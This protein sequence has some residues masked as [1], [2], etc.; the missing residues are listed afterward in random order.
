[1]TLS[2]RRTLSS[3]GIAA[4]TAAAAPLVSACSRASATPPDP[5]EAQQAPRGKTTIDWWYSSVAAKDGGDLAPRLI[6]AFR[7]RYPQISVNIIK[8]PASTDT[9]RSALSTQLAAGSASPDVYQGDITWAAQFGAASFALPV[10]SL[11]DEEEW[12]RYPKALLTSLGYQGHR[13]AFPLYQDQPYLYYRRDLLHK[14]GLR[15]PRTWEELM[16]TAQRVQRA[17][18]IKHGF[19]WQGSVYEGMTCNVTEILADAGG[20]ALSADG[21]RAT[22]AGPAAEQALGLMRDLV[23]SRVSPSAVSTFIEQ[24]T[25]DDFSAGRSLFLRNWPYAWGWWPTRTPPPWPGRSAPRCVPAS[26]VARAA[27][28]AWAAGATTSTRTPASWARPRPSPSSSPRRV[29]WSSPSTARSCPRP[30]RPSTAG[31]SAVRRT[32]STPW[33]WR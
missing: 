6:S 26:R 7:K 16:R 27:S 31:G 11:L 25:I 18:D 28:A 2:R 21:S 23:T 10:E 30:T 24:N 33:H 5:A 15:V 20:Q 13:Y 32:P 17:G 22:F 4:G 12:Q 9:Q 14:H 3:L 8:A 1:M 29:R 19:V